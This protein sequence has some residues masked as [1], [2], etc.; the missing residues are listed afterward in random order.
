M[1]F[2][3]LGVMY[4]FGRSCGSEKFKYPLTFYICCGIRMSLC[5]RKVS[6]R[7]HWNTLS[8]LYFMYIVF[9][10]FSFFYS[11]MVVIIL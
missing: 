5:A 2:T 3:S 1:F 6:D 11:R 10:Y 9:L 8:I 4:F 7:W